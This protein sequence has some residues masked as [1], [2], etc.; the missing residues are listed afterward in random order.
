MP[1]GPDLRPVLA[2]LFRAAALLALLALPGLGQLIG[3]KLPDALAQKHE[4]ILV[5][6]GNQKYLVCEPVSGFTVDVNS[7]ATKATGQVFVVCV[8][9]F[10]KPEAELYAG[11]DKE[12]NKKPA[13]GRRLAFTAKELPKLDVLIWDRVQTLTGLRDEFLRKR[14]E[15]DDKRK[16]LGAL[17]L[18]TP[19]WFDLQRTLLIDVDALVGWLR[20]TLFAPAAVAWEKQYAAEIKKAGVAASKSRLEEAKKISKVEVPENLPISTREGGKGD[21][22]WHAR[23]TKHVRMIAHGEIDGG[24]MDAALVL[25]ERIIEQVRTDFIDPYLQPGD[26]DPVKDEIFIE[27]L[28]C[29]VDDA[30][31]THLWEKYYGMRVG[32]PRAETTKMNHRGRGG[33]GFLSLAKQDGGADLEGWVAHTLG[34]FIGNVAFNGWADLPAW[35]GEGFAYWVSFEHLSRNS[36]TCFAWSVPTYARA[37]DKTGEKRVEEGL[38]AAFNQIALT[39]GPSMSDLFQTPLASMDG[40]FLA[41]AWSVMDWLVSGEPKRMREFLRAAGAAEE[42]GRTQ[43]EKFRPRAM[44]IFEVKSGDVYQALDETWRKFAAAGGGEARPRK[45]M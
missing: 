31:C 25:A 22:K 29:P 14:A 21:L 12:G 6:R 19:E 41:K 7:N 44:E 26:E 4:K 15:I 30:F 45:K 38:R 35:C 28:F 13:E 3:L 33:P 32:E 34:H 10:N 1:V 20:S 42:R 40:A 16:R 2:P 39:Q 23:A 17:K 24:R 11:V 5:A 36:V 8:P 18:G 9:D 37:A 27:Y 43:I